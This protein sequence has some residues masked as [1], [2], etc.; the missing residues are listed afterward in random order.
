MNKY[1]RWIKLGLFVLCLVPVAGLAWLYY[2]T[3]HGLEPDLGANPLEYLTHGTGT[4]TINFIMLT[5]CI[6]P[7]RKLL[8]MPWLIQMRKMLGLF[9]FFY[10]CLHFTCWLWFDKQF[11]WSDMGADI[12]KRK[13]VTAGMVALALMLPLAL[14][15]TTWAIRKMGGKRWQALHRLIYVTG[16]AAVIH[17]IW[18]VKADLKAPLQYAAIV[19]V[20]LGYRVFEWARKRSAASA[21]RPAPQAG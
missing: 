9:A 20:L 16:I 8:G 17:Y 14:T 11:I 1:I 13:F 6:T 2:N 18:L 4:W 21:N 12:L 5:L 3:T 7:A 10:G 19:A 15:S